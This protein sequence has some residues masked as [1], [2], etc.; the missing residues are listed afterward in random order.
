MQ[1]N[2]NI[3]A[4]AQSATVELA[5]RVRTLKAAGK[6]IIGLQTGDPDFDTPSPIREAAEDALK[7]GKTH[8]GPSRGIP[9]L[10]HAI[11]KER[12]DQWGVEYDPRTELLVTCGGVHA[13]F[14]ALMAILNPGDEVLVADPAWMTHVNAVSALG[15]RAVRVP[16]TAVDRF[17][18]PLDAW[19]AACTERT[20]AI[21]LNSPNNP[22][23]SVAE[24]DYLKQILE[25]ATRFGLYII[26][27]EVYEHIVF[28]GAHHT[29][30]AS[31]E[32]AFERVLTVNSFSKSYA[33]TGWRIG[34]LAARAE[35]IDSALKVGQ[36]TITNV[37]V[38]VQEAAHCALTDTATAR[39]REKMIAE[40]SQ[41]MEL[42]LKTLDEH[43]HSGLAATSPDGAIYLFLDARSTGIPS[44]D[45][46]TRLLDEAE[47][48]VVSGNVYGPGGEGFL[49][50][51]IAAS[52]NEITMGLSRIFDWIER[53]F[54]TGSKSQEST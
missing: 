34:Y 19:E 45:L 46:A 43:K 26:S 40:Y 25:L 4:I 8:Y 28:K 52:E 51:T 36:N 39:F 31:L 42:A 12:R 18:P 41:R 38:F 6:D 32:G 50:L 29:C 35:I 17:W 53:S 11:A 9:K 23:G 22:T 10:R 48:A 21:V 49:R 24:Q 20:I 14:C 13:Y 33:M 47:V 3:S 54:K 15:G 44:I 2:H 5:D 1:L 37:P 16:S 27:D 7:S 30:M